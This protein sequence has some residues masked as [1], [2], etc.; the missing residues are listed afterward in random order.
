MLALGSGSRMGDGENDEGGLRP[1]GP[2]GED[3]SEVFV[4]GLAVDEATFGGAAEAGGKDKG[5]GV[6]FCCLGAAR[7]ESDGD[8]QHPLPLMVAGAGAVTEGDIV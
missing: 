1:R 3:C 8:C 5:I 7:A 2:S 6:L 4:N